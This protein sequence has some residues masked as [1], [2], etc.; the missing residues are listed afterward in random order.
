M[1][2]SNSIL[3]A[4]WAGIDGCRGGWIVAYTDQHS[5][6]VQ[7][8]ASLHELKELGIQ[9]CLIDMPIGLSAERHIDQDL[10]Q[11][12]KPVRHHSV[13]STPVRAAVY[14]DEYALAKVINQEAT[15][16]SISIQSWNICAKIK[17][18]DQYI[19]DASDD[20]IAI[21]S[22]PEYCFFRLN[23]NKHLQHKKSTP[24]GVEERIK[25]L[26]TYQAEYTKAFELALKNFPRKAVKAD[27]ILDALC[28]H[29]TGQH[30][31]SYIKNSPLMDEKG[32]SMQIAFPTLH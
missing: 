13:F 20:F 14:A 23:Q 25:L 2:Q 31:L 11:V 1:A 24:A 17:E 29:L 21:E 3:N 22:H 10:R 30:E 18:L 28:L 32:I 16:K 12:L 26:H 6:A 15:R 7:W 4:Q 27:D 19:Q 9:T 8:I 5:I